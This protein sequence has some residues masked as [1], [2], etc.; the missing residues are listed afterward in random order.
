MKREINREV[1]KDTDLDMLSVSGQS[2]YDVTHLTPQNVR[3][4]KNTLSLSHKI[5]PVMVTCVFVKTVKILSKFNCQ[6]M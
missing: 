6:L 2:H 1:D 4:E 3:E 5:S